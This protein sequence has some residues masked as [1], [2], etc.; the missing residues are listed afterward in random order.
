MC[1][2]T[3]TTSEAKQDGD[4]ELLTWEPGPAPSLISRCPWMVTDVTAQKTV[5]I[6]RVALVILVIKGSKVWRKRE[7]FKSCEQFLV[8]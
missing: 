5:F 3:S 1:V 7:P 8:R 6:L 2:L 4:V